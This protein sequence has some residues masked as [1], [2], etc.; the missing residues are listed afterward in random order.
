MKEGRPRFFLST[1][2]HICTHMCAHTHTTK[3]THT[4][5]HTH[6]HTHIHRTGQRP[7]IQCVSCIRTGGGGS[8]T[9]VTRPLTTITLMVRTHR[10]HTLSLSLSLSHTHYIDSAN[11]WNASHTYMH[12]CNAYHVCICRSE[13]CVY[14]LCTP[15]VLST[16]VRGMSIFLCGV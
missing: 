3:H 8:G 2:V 14:M 15:C 5:R 1:N 11:T 9:S 13:P 16:D 6:T 4:L 12:V 10:T 7:M